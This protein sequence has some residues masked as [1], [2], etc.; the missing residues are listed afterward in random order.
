[1]IGRL[2]Y[3]NSDKKIDDKITSFIADFVGKSGVSPSI[4]EIS[5]KVYTEDII[6]PGIKVRPSK[7]VMKN[8][9][10]VGWEEL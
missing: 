8:Y 10:F 7:L 6:V 4:V 1:M 9:F 3:D 2:Y 5:P